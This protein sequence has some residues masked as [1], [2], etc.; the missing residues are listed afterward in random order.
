MSKSL[1]LKSILKVTAED[2]K[3]NVI[4]KQHPE[5][6]EIWVMILNRGKANAFTLEF[7]KEIHQ[8]LDILESI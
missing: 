2:E 7:V 6:K 4:L 3:K 5:N 8:N 1:N